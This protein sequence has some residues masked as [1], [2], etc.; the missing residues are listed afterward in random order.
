MSEES[1]STN[2]AKATIASA[3]KSGKAKS[4]FKSS[5]DV[6]AEGIKAGEKE[7]ADGEQVS[8]LDNAEILPETISFSSPEDLVQPDAQAEEV[9]EGEATEET[10]KETK[11]GKKIKIGTRFFDSEAEAFAYAEELEVQKL[12]DDAFRQGIE[13][14]Q[15]LTNS[16][17]L[18]ASTVNPPEEE[19]IPDEYYTNP[20]KFFKEQNAQVIARASQ[21][22]TEQVNRQ[23]RHNETMTKFW[24]DNPDLARSEAT[25]DLTTNILN[26]NFKALEHVPT[27]KALA[28][29]A[30]KARARLKDLGVTT[31]PTKTLPSTT[32]QVVSSGSSTTVARP[33]AEEKVLNWTEQMKNMK[34]NKAEARRHR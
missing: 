31:L 28:I 1:E 5:A 2:E 13:A 16:N 10:K 20:A 32:K 4:K 18:A 14:A 15:N 27:D 30:E 33:K 17:S 12:T 25:K 26:Q 23:V 7:V 34:R 29:V 21:L 9:T 22:A 19:K 24:S 6:I 8:T 3:M 11:T